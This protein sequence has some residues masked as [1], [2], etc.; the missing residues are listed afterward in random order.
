MGMKT[1]LRENERNRFL[2]WASWVPMRFYTKYFQGKEK[3]VEVDLNKIGVDIKFPFYIGKE[4]EMGSL[5]SELRCFKVREPNN[6]KH[7]SKFITKDDVLLDVGANFGFF[8]VLGKN[9]KEIIAIEPV[10]ECNDIL[11]KN[12]ALNDLTDK[13]KIFN[14]ALG[15]GGK[16]FMNRAESSNLSQVVESAE[17]GNYSVESKPLKYFVDKYN[18]NAVKMDV[19]GYEWE[20]FSKQKI[21]KEIN[22]ITLEFHRWELGMETSAKLIKIFYD[23]GF[24]VKYFLEDMPLRFYPFIGIKSILNRLTYVKKNLSLNECIEE[25]RKGRG[26]KYFYLVRK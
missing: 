2:E 19:E 22:K 1:L 20:I 18:V 15:N 23:Q 21:P 11:K 12:L 9:A 13:T 16:V 3:L 5:S 17:K 10:K 4:R 6:L 8:S 14:L 7:F 25:T 26:I 24:V